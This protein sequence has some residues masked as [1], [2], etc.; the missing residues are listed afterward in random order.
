[1][2]IFRRRIDEVHLMIILLI[3]LMAVSGSAFAQTTGPGDAIET[4]FRQDQLTVGEV[5]ARY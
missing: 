2:I 3:A 4:G 1:L 5:Y